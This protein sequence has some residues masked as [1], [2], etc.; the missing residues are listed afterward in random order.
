MFGAKIHR[1]IARIAWWIMITFGVG[2]LLGLLYELLKEDYPGKVYLFLQDS[3]LPPLDWIN[4]NA[5][6][7]FKFWFG[8]L[9]WAVITKFVIK[10][11]HPPV[12]DESPI[13]T[14]RM[15]IGWITLIILLLS[16]SY[17]GIYLIE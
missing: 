12:M 7:I 3:L 10:I 11:G 14:K 16:F 5:P 17:N 15:L 2:S 1:I 8:W 9:L 4:D 6:Y 13:G